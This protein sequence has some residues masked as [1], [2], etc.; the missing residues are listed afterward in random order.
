MGDRLDR[1]FGIE[2]AKRQAEERQVEAKAAGGLLNVQQQSALKTFLIDN[3]WMTPAGAD[4]ALTR[5]DDLASKK[6]LPSDPDGKP[7][8]IIKEAL[9]GLV[10]DAFLNNG[11]NFTGIT[12]MIGGAM[13]DLNRRIDALPTATAGASPPAKAA[14]PKPR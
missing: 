11:N 6:Y 12:K 9:S 2:E 10:K 3:C 13:L 1:L 7:D 4:K 8:A 14:P 5:I